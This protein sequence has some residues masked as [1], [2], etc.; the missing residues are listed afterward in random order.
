MLKALRLP[1]A[2]L[3]CFLF[4]MGLVVSIVHLSRPEPTEIPPEKQA[5][6]SPSITDPIDAAAFN[7]LASNILVLYKLNED[8]QR[9]L[10]L[11]SNALASRIAAQEDTLVMAIKLLEY[12][13]KWNSNQQQWNNNVLKVLTNH[14][15]LHP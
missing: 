11:S 5:A 15:S 4:F 14:V 2:L 10:Y 8:Q 6:P 13:Q 7:N 12:Q 9:G 1:A 3:I